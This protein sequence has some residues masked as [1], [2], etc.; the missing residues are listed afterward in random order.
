MRLLRELV[1]HYKDH[2]LAID[3]GKAFNK[4][5]RNVCPNLGGH[6]QGLQEP[7]GVKVLCLVLL[8]GGAGAVK[9]THQPAV[10]LDEEILAEALQ[11]LL[12]RLMANGMRQLKHNR[13]GLQDGQH[14]YSRA[15]QHQAINQTPRL[16]AI[17]DHR[18]V[19]SPELFT[20]LQLPSEIIKQL[21]R[22]ARDH[23]NGGFG[24][25]TPG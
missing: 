22:W 4:V 24:I 14:I 15:T 19:E 18:I 6:L 11:G 2:T 8:A 13:Q 5:E 21:K 20:I 7:S 17:H 23:V 9:I 25:F 3:A 12:C 10:M 16:T 1:N